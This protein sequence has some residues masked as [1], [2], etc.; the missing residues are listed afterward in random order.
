MYPWT[1][2]RQRQNLSAVSPAHHTVPVLFVVLKQTLIHAAVD[3]R[4]DAVVPHAVDVFA[5]VHIAV[6]LGKW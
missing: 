2:K 1:V 3:K 5:I 6:D 4:K